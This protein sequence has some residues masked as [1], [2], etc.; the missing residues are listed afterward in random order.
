MADLAKGQKAKPLSNTD[1]ELAGYLV[2]CPG[3]RC[4]HLFHTAEWDPG[5]GRIGPVW[6]FN[7]DVMKP[8]FGPSMLVNQNTPERRCRSFVRAGQIL[9][10]G[11]CF[12][13][14]R[15]QEVALP[16]VDQW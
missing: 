15:G 5:D 13:D 1:G 3:C 9:F 12:H 16:D 11:D 7:G 8:T 2:F 6:T 4:G 10:L 14:L